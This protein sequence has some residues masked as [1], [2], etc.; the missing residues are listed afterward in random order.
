MDRL[1]Q[2]LEKKFFPILKYIFVDYRSRL[3]MVLS[4]HF[5]AP[6]SFNPRRKSQHLLRTPLDLMTFIFFQQV[7]CTCGAKRSTLVSFLRRQRLIRTWGLM[8]RLGYLCLPRTKITSTHP[9]LAFPWVLGL[10]DRS[11]SLCGKHFTENHLHRTLNIA[12]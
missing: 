11:S 12:S 3:A 10:E 6:L 4:V 2:A 9:C 7:V 5:F 1:R 8:I